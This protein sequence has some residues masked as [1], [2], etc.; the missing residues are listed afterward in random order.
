MFQ[1]INKYLRT[2]FNFEWSLQYYYIIKLIKLVSCE[3]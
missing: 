2:I 1:N 3:T